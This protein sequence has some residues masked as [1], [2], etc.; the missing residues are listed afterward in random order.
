[1]IAGF[2]CRNPWMVLNVGKNFERLRN[3]C[4]SYIAAIANA[5]LIAGH[6]RPRAYL[7][8]LAA[9][10]AQHSASLLLHTGN[11]RNYW[12]VAFQGNLPHALRFDP[13]DK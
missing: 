9:L 1:M 12:G 5:E 8:Q 2:F 10:H 4:H 7:A 3:P 6:A 13:N 11:F